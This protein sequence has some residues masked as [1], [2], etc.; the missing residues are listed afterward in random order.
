[1]VGNKHDVKND[2]YQFIGRSGVTLVEKYVT[3]VDLI[4]QAGIPEDL[5]IAKEFASD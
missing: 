1:V 4:W 2:Q 5:L 3:D